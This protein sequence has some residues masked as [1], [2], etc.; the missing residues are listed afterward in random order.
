M[1][2]AWTEQHVPRANGEIAGRN[3]G[4]MRYIWES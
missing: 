2:A 3:L 4:W 1:I